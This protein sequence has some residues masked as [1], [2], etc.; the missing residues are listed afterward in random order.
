MN[1]IMIDEDDKLFSLFSFSFY[2]F[3][4][5]KCVYTLFFLSRFIDHILP[6]LSPSLYARNSLYTLL[7]FSNMF[8]SFPLPIH[9]LVLFFSC[10]SRTRLHYSSSYI[11]SLYLYHSHDHRLSRVH[12]QSLPDGPVTSRVEV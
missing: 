12:S 4:F 8:A 11:T 9:F 6:C 10:I 7:S 2:L 3:Y 1:V 5:F